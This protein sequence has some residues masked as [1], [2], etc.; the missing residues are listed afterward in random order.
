MISLIQ[1][2]KVFF[3]NKTGNTC[4]S[5]SILVS[6]KMNTSH[7]PWVRK[8][9]RPTCCNFLS[10]DSA[11]LCAGTVIAARGMA[12]RSHPGDMEDILH[13]ACFHGCMPII[14]A[15]ATI[16]ILN[17]VSTSTSCIN[18]FAEYATQSF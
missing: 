15:S 3:S 4:T 9:A 7:V 13:I 11:N 10:Q 5:I 16:C 12:S 17:Y 18:N 6:K 8:A 1:A 2:R 14:A